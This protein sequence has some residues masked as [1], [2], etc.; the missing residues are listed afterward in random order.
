MSYLYL[1]TR[2]KV[3]SFW[4][5]SSSSAAAFPL[6]LFVKLHIECEILNLYTHTQK[7]EDRVITGCI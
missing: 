6:L 2:V 1:L 7:E 5:H 3:I 4:S